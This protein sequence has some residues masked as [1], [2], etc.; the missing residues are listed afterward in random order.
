MY[1]SQYINN[2]W[3]YSDLLAMKMGRN[4]SKFLL[5]VH[6]INSIFQKILQSDTSWYKSV[7]WLFS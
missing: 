6:I 3:G 7:L 2:P 1:Q 5:F 4:V